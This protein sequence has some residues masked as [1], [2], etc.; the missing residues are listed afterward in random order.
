MATAAWL[1]GERIV[2]LFEGLTALDQLDVE[3]TP[4]EILGLIGPNGAGKTTLVNVLTGFQRPSSGTISVDG[5]DMTGLPPQRFA[6]AGIARTFQ[7]VRI[8]RDMT[9]LD[10]LE[11]AAVAKG[12]NRG[13]AAREAAE[14]L[15]WFGLGRKAAVAADTLSYGEERI[16]GIARALMG[17]PRYLLLDEP[18]AGLNETEA[19]ELMDHIIELPRRF[20]CGVMLIEHNMQVVMGACQRIQVIG[21][22]STLAEGSPREIQANRTVIE[23]YLGTRAGR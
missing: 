13:T 18:A 8:F 17:R 2:V 20:G 7:N 11:V 15:E 22:G 4:T 14:L 21:N 16:L 19:R 10:N 5:R 9:V 3:L 23:A 1:R 12:A 6:H